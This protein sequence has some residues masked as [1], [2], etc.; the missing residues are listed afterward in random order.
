LGRVSD[1]ELRALYNGALAFLWPPLSEGFGIPPL[2]AMALGVPVAASRTSAMPEVLGDAPEWFDP[3]D[4]GDMAEAILRLV[5]LS[6]PA[7]SA[8]IERGRDRAKLWTWDQSA[9]RLH[10]LLAEMG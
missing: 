8:M 3:L 5:I 6:G 7:R 2:E 4:E 1:G 10:E 9:L